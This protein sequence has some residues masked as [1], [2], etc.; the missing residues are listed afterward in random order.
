[1]SLSPA[2]IE[3][4][5][6]ALV[7]KGYDPAEV[8]AFLRQLATRV[9]ESAAD[10]GPIGDQVAMVLQTA[11]ETAAAIV[12]KAEDD[13]RAANADA[14]RLRDEAER[15][16]ASAQSDANHTLADAESYAQTTRTSAD[17]YSVSIR[18]QTDEYAVGAR[19]QAD[20]YSAVTRATADE[21]SEQIRSIAN[22]EATAIRAQAEDD[23]NRRAQAVLAATQDRLDSLIAT[24]TAIRERVQSVA[25]ELQ[26]IAQQ[27][28]GTTDVVDLTAKADLEAA[29]PVSDEGAPLSRVVWA[30]A[31]EALAQHS[32]SEP[33]PA[34]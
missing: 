10:F 3:A 22:D 25:A 32:E 20:E 16:R 9:A 6:F 7:R 5:Q 29:P 31:G 8:D 15:I 26:R 21:H 28:A 27:V 30:A 19:S 14:D 33:S 12:E 17:E 1:M 24:E 23:A 11:N 13:A 4:K 18:S 34:G 2:E